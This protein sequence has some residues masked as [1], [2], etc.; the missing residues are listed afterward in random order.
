MTDISSQENFHD[1]ALPIR[2][3]KF[4]I[5]I[6]LPFKILTSFVP[7]LAEYGR[8]TEAGYRPELRPMAFVPIII[9]D[10]FICFLIYGLH[11]RRLWGWICNWFFM[12]SMVLF[13]PI[14]A[15]TSIGAYIVAVILLFLIFFLPNCFYFKKR[16]SLFA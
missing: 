6:F 11:K 13:S 8:L 4:Y 9:W 12:G 15:K 10:I 2:W 5:Y 16:R 7:L 3:F 1:T 14:D